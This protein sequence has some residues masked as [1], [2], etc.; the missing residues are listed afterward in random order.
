MGSA[1]QEQKRAVRATVRQ[2]IRRINPTQ[3]AAASASAV[4]L[5]LEQEQWKKAKSVLLFTPLGDELDLL[6]CFEEARTAGK[7]IALPRYLPDQAVYCAAMYEGTPETLSRG[8]FGVPEPRVNAPVVPLNRLDLALV[9]GVAFDLSG[10][11]LG[12]GR[13]F[14]DRLLAE[15][16]GVKCGVAFDEQIVPELP[17]EPHD[18]AMDFIL[19]PTRWLLARAN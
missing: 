17:E 3:R 8:Q 7:L 1:V 19:T 5:L 15:V 6:L 9:P 10:R 11:R 2:S 14:Y 18:M 16:T 4:A 12:R 13:G